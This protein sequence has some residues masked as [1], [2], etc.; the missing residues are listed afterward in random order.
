MIVF[1]DSSIYYGIEALLF[2]L[3]EF[4]YGA[5]PSLTLEN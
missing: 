1:I 3:L 5:A 4:A 2:A